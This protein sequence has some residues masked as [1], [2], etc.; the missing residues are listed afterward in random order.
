MNS[1]LGV[2]VFLLISQSAF[3]Q[4]LKQFLRACGYGTLAGAGLGV[5]SLV[6]EKK[7][8]ESYGNIARG[9]SLGL[10]GGMAYGLISRRPQNDNTSDIVENQQKSFYLI[11]PSLNGTIETVF[12]YR[13]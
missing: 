12:V 1:K 3:S 2:V 8:N 10:Y 7:P 5:A 6:F 11:G 4:D 13:F 9:A